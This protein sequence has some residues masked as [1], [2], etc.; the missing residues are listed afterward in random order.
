MS[1][2]VAIIPARKG[3]KRVL[4]KNVRE[5]HDRPL[6]VFSIK[7][8]LS[9]P[10]IDTVIVST[11]DP[12]VAAVSEK[13]DVE[14]WWR[15]EA[16]SQDGSNT[17]DVLKYIYFKLERQQPHAPEFFVLLQ[18]TSPLR[19]RD[20]ISKGLEAI[21]AHPQ[22][23]SLVALYRQ[24]AFKGCIRDG[25]WYPDYPEATRSQDI[26]PWYIPTGALFIYRCAETIKKN[27]ALGDLTLPLIEDDETVV[28][29]DHESDF[30][31]LEFVYTEYHERY[32]YLLS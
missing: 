20:L 5:F 10:E 27:D 13:Y 30:K 4:N 32:D 9:C 23:T 22:A 29:I 18:P 25:F 17:F 2:V 14:T 3:S 7:A 28:N 31:K 19:T 26:E 6:V 1:N 21:R 8:A 16:L 11:N 24:Q 12:L 15:P